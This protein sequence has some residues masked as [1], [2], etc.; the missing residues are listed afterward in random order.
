MK[1]LVLLTDGM[2]DE[3]QVSL[4]GKTPIEYA[5]TPNMDK[6]ATGGECGFIRTVPDGFAPGSDVCN[7]SIFGYNPTEYYTGR[8]PLEAASMGVA[9]GDNDTVFRCNLVTLKDGCMED[10]SAHH[11]ANADAAVAIGRLHAMFGGLGIDF[12]QGLSYRHIMVVRDRKISVNTTPPHDITGQTYEKELPAGADSIFLQE[13]MDKAREVFKNDTGMANSIWLWG[14]G[15][16]PAMPSFRELYGVN[17]AC[18][19][20]VDLVKGIATCAGLE[21]INVPGATGFIDTNYEGKAMHA[22]K[23]LHRYD[24]VYVHV[25]APDEAGHMGKTD[26][27]V[28]AIEDI[29][30]RMLPTIIEGMKG[31]GEYRILLTPDHPTPIRIMTHAS[32]PV[33]AILWGTGIDADSNTQYSEHIKPS[34]NIKHGFQIAKKLIL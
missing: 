10:F 4:G 15:V 21:I 7:M 1:Y 13:I 16:R 3:P 22:I 20:A 14:Q 25:E 2:S 34:F 19:A 26:L 18:I 8:G 29:D 17:G 31:F 24:Y 23:A 11:I 33:P 9:L 32:A 6:L 28:K 30:S 5:T 27:K 12:Y